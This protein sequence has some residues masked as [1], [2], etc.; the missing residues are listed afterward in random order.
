MTWQETV[1]RLNRC[2]IVHTMVTELPDYSEYYD[3]AQGLTDVYRTSSAE[4][5][6][7]IGKHLGEAAAMIL[8]HYA[9]HL[10]GV[11]DGDETGSLIRRGLAALALE[12]GRTEY[13][14]TAVPLHF[15]LKAARELGLNDRALLE[16]GA[17]LIAA[18]PNDG[19]V[20][21]YKNYLDSDAEKNFGGW[22]IE[23]GQ[24]RL[25]ID[26]S[27]I[28]RP[29]LASRIVARIRAKLMLD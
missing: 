26:L 2:P 6:E 17:G 15:L 11:A 25:D 19:F 21:L 14:S 27:K 29:S 3:S 4:V 13:H 1:G 28:K 10:A 20:D 23:G 16:E 12:G 5:R 9:W 18:T 24:I 7:T 8:S 22:R